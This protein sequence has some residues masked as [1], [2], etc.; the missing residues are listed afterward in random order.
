MVKP[1][2]VL[3]VM[4]ILLYQALHTTYQLVPI[5]QPLEHQSFDTFLPGRVRELGN[6]ITR[7]EKVGRLDKIVSVDWWILYGNLSG[8]LHCTNF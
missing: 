6:K 4:N 3:A 8:G 1:L 5:N 7:S 2:R